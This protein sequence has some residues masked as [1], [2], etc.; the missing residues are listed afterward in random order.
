MCLL[1]VP[2]VEGSKQRILT[3]TLSGL[4]RGVSIQ[5]THGNQP[6]QT[7]TKYFLSITYRMGAFHNNYKSYVWLPLYGIDKW[8]DIF[9]FLRGFAVYW[10]G[11]S[12]GGF[13]WQ[14]RWNSRSRLQ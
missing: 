11:P 8:K 12:S 2:K 14:H 7:P 5:T 10:R 6:L 4:Q 1:T 13:L 3:E 9:D